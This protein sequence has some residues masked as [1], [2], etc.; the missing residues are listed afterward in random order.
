MRIG[1]GIHAPTSR[2]PA[3]ATTIPAASLAGFRALRRPGRYAVD[4]VTRVVRLS[5]QCT[6]KPV[7]TAWYRCRP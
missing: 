6:I 2:P 3:R 7:N 1:P 4:A 5:S